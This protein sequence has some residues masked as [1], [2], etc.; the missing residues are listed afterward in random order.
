MLE[1]NQSYHYPYKPKQHFTHYNKSPDIQN[2]CNSNNIEPTYRNP[3]DDQPK[4]KATRRRYPPL[5]QS[6]L[7]KSKKTIDGQEL[8]SLSALETEPDQTFLSKTRNKKITSS[9]AFNNLCLVC[10]DQSSG[11]H[12]GVNT[13][14]GCKVNI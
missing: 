11:I 6:T 2:E 10:G 4:R 13:C 5:S 12:Y 9:T 3:E 1:S 8:L 7:N 14:E